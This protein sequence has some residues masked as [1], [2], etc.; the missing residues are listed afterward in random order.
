M[1]GDYVEPVMECRVVGKT[2]SFLKTY[3]MSRFTD[4]VDESTVIVTVRK[5]R[6]PHQNLEVI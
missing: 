3:D 2:D 1:N 5:T 4:V 6:I